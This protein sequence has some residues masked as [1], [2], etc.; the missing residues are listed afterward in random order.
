MIH[1]HAW[2]LVKAE[3]IDTK[4]VDFAS[5]DGYTELYF[6]C[7]RPNCYK[8]HIETRDGLW[9]MQDFGVDGRD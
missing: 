3:Y 5:S 7:S 9:T 4:H 2:N 1:W 6:S 8:T